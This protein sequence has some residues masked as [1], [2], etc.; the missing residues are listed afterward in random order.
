METEID[1]RESRTGREK[2]EEKVGKRRAK[3]G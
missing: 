2:Q 1:E 3:E